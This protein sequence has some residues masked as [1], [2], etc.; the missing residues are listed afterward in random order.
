MVVI[1]TMNQK[2]DSGNKLNISIKLHFEQAMSAIEMMDPKMDSGMN[3][4]TIPLNFQTA[5]ETGHLP[6]KE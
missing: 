1:D 2:M 6:L 3:T 4:S 5:V